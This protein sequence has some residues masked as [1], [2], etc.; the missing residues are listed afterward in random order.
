MQAQLRV[1]VKAQIASPYTIARQAGI[2]K[3]AMSR[4]M[5]GASLST[6]NIERLTIALGLQ[7]IATKIVLPATR[8]R[9]PTT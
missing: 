9:P 5:G 1:I 2:D 8:G 3:S 7:I 6:T 4:F